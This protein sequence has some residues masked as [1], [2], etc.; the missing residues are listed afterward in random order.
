MGNSGDFRLWRSM[1]T[2]VPHNR[3][4]S[5]RPVGR[6]G[7]LP[8]RIAP[9][10]SYDVVILGAGSGGYAAA[11]RAAQ[12]GLNVALVEKDKV[13]GTCL[14]RGCIPTKAFLHAAEVA[15]NAR[16]GA[17]FGVHTTLAEVKVDEVVKYAGGVISRLYKG[18]TGLVK[19]RDVTVVEGEG[20]LVSIP[21]G[22][23][24]EVNGEQL[25]GKYTILASGSFSRTLGI[26]ID[27]IRTLT[28]EHA[29]TMES[30]PKSA[31]VLGGGV[32]GVEFASIWNSFGVNVTIVEALDRLVPHEE[33]EISK[34]LERA[35]KKRKITSLVGS[36]VK[37]VELVDDGVK[38]ELENRTLEA[39]VLLI[40][41]GR[42]PFTEGLGYE[43]AGVALERGFVTVDDTLTTSVPNV[44]AV[45]DIVRGVQLAHRGFAHGIFVAEK[46]AQAE[47]KYQGDPELVCDVDIPKITYCNPEI[48]SVGLSEAAARQ[49]YGEGVK[50]LQY[51]LG[52]NGKSQILKTQGFIKLVAAPDE[53]IV[54]VHM[55]GARVGE[56]IGEAQLITQWEARANEVAS[57]IHAHPTQN[58]ALGEAHLALAGKPLHAHS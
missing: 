52:G 15:D 7:D 16:E 8:A 45:G 33:P 27:G 13:G 48:A 26:E 19:G 25:V 9:M 6:R 39:D 56:L 24:I 30:L 34:A 50:T 22:V 44:Y 42:G 43:E 31:I 20:K 51:D 57:L 55:M 47:G 32:I 4:G 2:R 23:A 28:S 37:G 53:T 36:P 10:T 14:H 12:L 38:V 1:P 21:D 3:S 17:Q 40:A 18:L 49:K 35:F 29:L 41:V 11:L 46:I 5:L 58:E 54:G